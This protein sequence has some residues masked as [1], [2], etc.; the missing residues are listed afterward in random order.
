MIDVYAKC[1]RCGEPIVGDLIGNEVCYE[2]VCFSEVNILG[3]SRCSIAREDEDDQKAYAE[4]YALCPDC[5][6]DTLDFVRGK[7]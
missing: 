6:A 2:A 7:E 3:I 4:V 1:S 5:L